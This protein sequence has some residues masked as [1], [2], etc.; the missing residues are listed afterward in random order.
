MPSPQTV[1]SNACG[2]SSS[3]SAGWAVVGACSRP[4][5]EMMYSSASAVAERRKALAFECITS[6]KHDLNSAVALDSGAGQNRSTVGQ[7]GSADSLATEGGRPGKTRND[8]S[9]AS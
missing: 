9:R 3:T 5:E 8:T 7:E 6:P 1:P 4:T 2:Y